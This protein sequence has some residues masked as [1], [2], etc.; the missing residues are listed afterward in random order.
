MPQAYRKPHLYL[1]QT[2]HYKDSGLIL[3]R[4]NCF[5]SRVFDQEKI[6]MSNHPPQGSGN[7]TPSGGMG[8]QQ[9]HHESQPQTQS[10]T[11][12]NLNQIVRLK[13]TFLYRARLLTPAM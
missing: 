5:Y 10:M 1:N 2:F 9:H 12:Q 4:R 11:Q 3:R 8:T 13:F 6:A 7:A